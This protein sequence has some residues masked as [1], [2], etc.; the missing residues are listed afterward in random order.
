MEYIVK[1]QGHPNVTARHKTTL[2]ITKEPHLTLRGDCIIG[3]NSSASVY[4]L[5]DEIKNKIR[6]NGRIDFL[7]SVENFSFSF[8]GYGHRDLSL[9]HPTDIVIRKSEFISER[10]LAIRSSAAAM[11]LPREIVAILRTGAHGELKI[12]VD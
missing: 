12:S 9:S 11:D 6:K 8:F 3:V 5:P 4:D 10:T 1:F 2:E 7:I